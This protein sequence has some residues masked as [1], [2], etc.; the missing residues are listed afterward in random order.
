MSASDQETI[1]SL[2]RLLEA[3]AVS[4]EDALKAAFQLGNF[5]GMVEMAKASQ[6]KV[7]A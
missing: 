4:P 7:P 1:A 5:A 2:A 3:K 6:P